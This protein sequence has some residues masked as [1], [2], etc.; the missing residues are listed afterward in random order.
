MEKLGTQ[1][2][3]SLQGLLTLIQPEMSLDIILQNLVINAVYLLLNEPR[4]ESLWPRDP[5]IDSTNPL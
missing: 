5:N 1:R 2:I 4:A 3:Q